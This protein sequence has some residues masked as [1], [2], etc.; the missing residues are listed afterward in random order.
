M[1]DCTVL[2]VMY[3]GKCTEEIEFGSVPCISESLRI[4]CLAAMM[5]FP[6]SFR[7]FLV[8]FSRP[9]KPEDKARAM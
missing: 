6:S 2:L 9:Q 7:S 3:C 5:G 1:L 8:S 4:E